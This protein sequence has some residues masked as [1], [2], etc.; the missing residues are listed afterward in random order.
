MNQHQFGKDKYIFGK[1]KNEIKDFGVQ[2][3][4]KKTYVKA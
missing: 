4:A 1:V 2:K 3:P